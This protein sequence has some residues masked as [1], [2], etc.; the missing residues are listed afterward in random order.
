MKFIKANSKKIFT[1]HRNMILIMVVGRKTSSKSFL[2]PRVPERAKQKK[3]IM[4]KSKIIVGIWSL[5]MKK[6]FSSKPYIEILYTEIHNH[7]LEI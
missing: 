7:P 4:N 5:L 3:I 1:A 2:K 6:T